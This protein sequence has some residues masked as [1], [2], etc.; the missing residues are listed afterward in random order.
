DLP[1]A[2]GFVAPLFLC[3]EPWK[4][5]SGENPPRY[6]ALDSAVTMDLYLAIR[7]KLEEEGRWTAFE[8]HCIEV[9]PILG[10]MSQAGVMLDTVYQQRFKAGLEI[11]RDV[12]ADVLQTEVP[13]AVKT[14]KVY[15][16]KPSMR[17]PFNPASPLQVKRLIEHLG[18]PVPKVRGEDRESTEAK[19]LKRFA[20]KHKVFQHILDYR[21]RAK[22]IDAYMWP[23]QSDGRVHTTFSFHPST[24]RK[25]SRDPNVQTIPKRND[26]A[27][28]FRRCIIA[29]PGHLLVEVDSS[30]I[31]AVLTGFYAGSEDVIR[32]AKAGIHGWMV[33]ACHDDSIPLN[34]PDAELAV[35]CK[36]AKA[37][38]GVQ[39]YDRM[40]RVVYLSFYMGTPQRIHEEYPL[41]FSSVKQARELQEFLFSTK[42]GQ[43]IKAWQQQTLQQA[44]KEH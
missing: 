11:E 26:L 28:E 33:A 36:A 2:L 37:E 19:Y 22:L 25:S 39:E 30:A 3:L 34:L 17:L 31:E 43:D 20:K 40:K 42:P 15:K 16:T 32:L 6:S 24:W 14:L 13:D 29:A 23:A 27:E 9:F 41:D 38:W 5:L 4:H 21:E 44:H 35:Q 18:L 10:Q 1:K 7:Q 8:R 12:A